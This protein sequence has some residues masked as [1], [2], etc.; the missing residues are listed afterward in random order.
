MSV[1]ECKITKYTYGAPFCTDAVVGQAAAG[2][3]AP[4]YIT[5]TDNGF[6]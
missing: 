1:N 5:E 4:S 2:E 3:G 6:T